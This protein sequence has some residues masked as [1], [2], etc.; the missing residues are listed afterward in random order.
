MTPFPPVQPDPRVTEVLE[1]LARRLE[2][3]VVR[4][5]GQYA[6][7]VKELLGD[8]YESE[9]IL[10][11]WEYERAREF[12]RDRVV[13]MQAVQRNIPQWVKIGKPRPGTKP[14]VPRTLVMWTPDYGEEHRGTGRSLVPCHRPGCDYPMCKE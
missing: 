10:G 4:P 14:L 11:A 2:I 7:A 3:P 8:G 1:E 6:T 5:Y 12:Y 9:D 13:S